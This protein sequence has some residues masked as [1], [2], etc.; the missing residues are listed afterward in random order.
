MVT[1][2]LAHNVAKA[3]NY[4]RSLAEVQ[5]KAKPP[6]L[7]G[8]VIDH[9]LRVD[10]DG[11]PPVSIHAWVI[12]PS[13]E[14]L[15]H[16]EG[17]DGPVF[18]PTNALPRTT[19]PPRGTVVVLHGFYDFM[20]QEA[21]LTWA[22]ILA[23]AGY[24][25][26]LVELRG[27]GLSTGDYST[28][29]VRES[30]DVSALLDDMEERGL[31]VEPLGVMAVSMGASTGVQ[32]A[33]HDPRVDAVVLISTFTSMR[34]VVPDFGRA[35]GFNGFSDEYYQTIVSRAGKLAHFDPDQATVI[36]RLPR[37][38]QPVLMFHG[39]EDNLIPIQHS[40]RLY[41][42]AQRDDIELIRVAG[43]NHTTLGGVVMEPIRQPMLDWL[44]RYMYEEPLADQRRAGDQAKAAARLDSP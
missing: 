8:T 10:V 3:P 35:I 34:A 32:L 27:H 19:L 37:L 44:Q 23:A 21:Y 14:Q 7:P 12:D 30:A 20:N 36:D 1:D 39:E 38:D 28:Y 2:I 24:R 11:D 18:E 6:V 41:N 17:E 5:R 40:I 22:R 31:L 43:A 25:A 4:H 26:V 15:V 16:A 9:D 33:E 13:N 42:A 29:G